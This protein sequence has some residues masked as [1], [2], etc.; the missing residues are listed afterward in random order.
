MIFYFYKITDYYS[1]IL[2]YSTILV[3][4]ISHYIEILVKN[5]VFIH[6]LYN[7]YN[8]D[9]KDRQTVHA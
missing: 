8:A 2:Q 9:S 7:T 4:I 5:K 6:V 1:Y 3:E